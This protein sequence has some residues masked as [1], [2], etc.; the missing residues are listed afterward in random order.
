MALLRSSVSWDA[1]SPAMAVG[2]RPGDAQEPPAPRGCH[3]RIL[4]VKTQRG[5]V[6]LRGRGKRYPSP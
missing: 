2:L 6:G 3:R 5:S 4:P 1:A